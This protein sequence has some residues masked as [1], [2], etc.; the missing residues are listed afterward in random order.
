LKAWIDRMNRPLP[1][2]DLELSEELPE[3]LTPILRGLLAEMLPYIEGV[4]AE[5]RRAAPHADGKPVPRFLGPVTHPYAGARLTRSAMVYVLWMVQRTHDAIAQMASQDQ[6]T[7]RTWLREMGGDGLL[8]L[9]VP[10][11]E[12]VG[13]TV[14]LREPAVG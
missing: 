9:D 2:E 6:E 8:R 7:V 12:R 3:S 13:L 11:L 1:H 10:R 5:L 14:C 4:V